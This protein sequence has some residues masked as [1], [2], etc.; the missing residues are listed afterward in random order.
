MVSVVHK[1]LYSFLLYRKGPICCDFRANLCVLS[2][3]PL[4]VTN[5][6]PLRILPICVSV[7]YETHSRFVLFGNRHTSPWLDQDVVFAFIRKRRNTS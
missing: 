2:A 4:Y 5:R 6:W 1:L 3:C 7:A